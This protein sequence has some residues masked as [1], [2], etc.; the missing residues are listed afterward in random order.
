ML[1]DVRRILTDAALAVPRLRLAISPGCCSSDAKTDL[2]M[3]RTAVSV[4]IAFFDV[5]RGAEVVALR[6]ADFSISAGL[7]FAR[8]SIRRQKNDQV[9]EGSVS[10]LPSMPGW[11]LHCRATLLQEWVNLR[12]AVA[13]TFDH[14]ARISKTPTSATAAAPD[15]L[16]I[17]L[18]GPR[19][20]APAFRRS[21]PQP[22]LGSLHPGPLQP[23]PLAQE[24]W[25]PMV[26]CPGH[27]SGSHPGPRRVEDPCGRGLHLRRPRGSRTPARDRLGRFPRPRRTSTPGRPRRPAIRRRFYSHD[28]PRWR[29]LLFITAG[30]QAAHSPP[31]VLGRR[32]INLCPGFRLAHPP[33]QETC[34]RRRQGPPRGYRLRL[35]PLNQTRPSCRGH[36]HRQG[37]F[38][39]TAAQRPRKTILP[40]PS[41]SP[42]DSLPS[43]TPPTCK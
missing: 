18:S 40:I 35:H 19:W 25:H 10:R 37:H 39:R 23:Y 16:F 13:D 11:G 38:A 14:F 8:F 9:G 4:A 20:G 43:M 33:P 7:Q 21:R 42:E 31:F 29:R 22:A 24:G 36:C 17:T 3:L 28:R 27:T 30:P 1:E 32:G 12:S 2:I 5:R 26:R 15:A 34:A 6:L 41:A